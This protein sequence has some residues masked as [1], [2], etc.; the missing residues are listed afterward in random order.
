[1]IT[2]TEQLKDIQISEEGPISWGI[3][4][5][6][7]EDGKEIT[8]TCKRTSICPDHGEHEDDVPLTELPSLVQQAVADNWTTELIANYKASLPIATEEVEPVE[9]QPDPVAEEA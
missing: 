1:M 3:D 6:I 7:L 4:I 8:R 2:K 9:E 5:I